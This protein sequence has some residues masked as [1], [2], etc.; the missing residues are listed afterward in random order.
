MRRGLPGVRTGPVRADGLSSGQERLAW[1]GGAGRGRR[2]LRGGEPGPNLPLSMM[3]KDPAGSRASRSASESPAASFS[4]QIPAPM[5]L[6][7]GPLAS[8]F[9]DPRRRAR[10]RGGSGPSPPP[11][12]LPGDPRARGPLFGWGISGRPAAR[13]LPA[14]QDRSTP[15]AHPCQPRTPRPTPRRPDVRAWGCRWSPN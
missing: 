10:G 6:L 8:A 4:S 13:L 11:T 2:R 7:G 3:A 12:A 15:P 5:G 9:S 1:R 14:P